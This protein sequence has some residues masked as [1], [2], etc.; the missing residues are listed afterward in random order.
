[1]RADLSVFSFGSIKT[2]TAFGGGISI[3]RNPELY[4]KM[5]AFHDKYPYL[6]K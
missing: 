4:K 2:N 6:S 1:M 3:I 5:I